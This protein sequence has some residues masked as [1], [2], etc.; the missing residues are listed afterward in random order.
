[1]VYRL[2]PDGGNP[3]VVFFTGGVVSSAGRAL[4][5]TTGIEYSSRLMHECQKKARAKELTLEDEKECGRP[6]GVKW[7]DGK[8]YVLDAYH[9]LFELDVTKGGRGKHLINSL[10]DFPLP[11]GGTAAAETTLP[12]TFLNDFDLTDDGT[13]FLT[14]SSWKHP[15]AHNRRDIIDGGPNGR[16][17]RFDPTTGDLRTVM[18]GLHFANGVLVD[19]SRKKLL[20]VES[21]RF[22]VLEFDVQGL[23]SSAGG[24][25]ASHLR[26]CGEE[27][28]LPDGVRV[29]AKALPGFVDNLEFDETR[30]GY[31][32][33]A[34]TKVAAP[35]SALHLALKAPGFF[36]TVLGKLL[37]MEVFEKLVPRYGLV[38]VLGLDG[39]VKES[40]H[41]TTGRTAF[42]SSAHRADKA[43][44]YT[45]LGSSQ[46]PYLGRVRL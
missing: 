18:C 5:S 32:A 24:T 37:P 16:L 28:A 36:R 25:P 40:M 44:G 9:G 30:G 20:V 14:D 43:G 31:V 8:L 35:F 3:T 26:Y 13:I 10:T 6:L 1:M 4:G 41:D 45:F 29:F 21:V 15:R 12:L 38:F 42:L 33:A 19:P 27:E 39:R 23:L 7:R 22:R 2:D 11:L 34:G 17:L 46:N